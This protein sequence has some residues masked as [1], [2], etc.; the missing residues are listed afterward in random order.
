MLIM[1]DKQVMSLPDHM[2]PVMFKRFFKR[3][4][5]HPAILSTPSPSISH[6]VLYICNHQLMEAIY[7]PWWVKGACYF[8]T[9]QW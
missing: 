7:H 9:E 1:E 5:C 6:L 2:A 3:L 8:K 4:S